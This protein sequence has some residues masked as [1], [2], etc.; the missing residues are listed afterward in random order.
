[1][2]TKGLTTAVLPIEKKYFLPDGQVYLGDVFS[3]IHSP[4]QGLFRIEFL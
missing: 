3:Y 2:P 4:I 1:M